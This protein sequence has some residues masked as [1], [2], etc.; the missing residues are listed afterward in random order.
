MATVKFSDE[1]PKPTSI[2]GTDRFLISDGV[3]GEAKA[4][5]FNQAK[6]Y[7]NITGIEMEPLV[8]GDSSATALVVANGPAGEQRTAEVSSG[9]WYDFGSGPV[10]ASADRRWKS[11]WNGTSWSLKDMGALP[12]Q[13]IDDLTPKGGFEGTSQELKDDI[14]E[15]KNNYFPVEDEYLHLFSDKNNAVYGFSNRNGEFDIKLTENAKNEIQ[16]VKSSNE[17]HVFSIEGEGREAALYISDTEM[18]LRGSQDNQSSP[19]IDPS[20]IYVSNISKIKSRLVLNSIAVG[21]A[22]AIGVDDAVKVALTDSGYTHPKMLYIPQGWNGYKYWLAITPTFGIIA[23]QVG[24]A[25]FEN[26]H[27]F[28]SNDAINWIEP[29]QN[30]IDVP[31]PFSFTNVVYPFNSDTHLLIGDDGWMYCYYRM[32]DM[33]REYVNNNPGE[34]GVYKIAMVCKKSRDGVNWSERIVVFG[35]DT[36]GVNAENLPKAQAYF[37]KGAKVQC[38]DMVKTSALLPIPPQKNQ[39]EMFIFRRSSFNPAE[40]NEPYT[41]DKIIDLENRPWGET[42]DPWHIDGE[43]VD[44]IYYLLIA[45]GLIDSPMASDLYLATSGDGWKFKV[46]PAPIYEGSTYRSSLTPFKI[47]EDGIDFLVMRADTSDG[48]QDLLKLEVKYKKG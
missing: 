41:I 13:P 44:G 35:D 46:H 23:E 10:Q 33:P 22:S 42:K 2:K 18:Y 45:V 4:P 12:M 20:K 6:E 19:N 16:N 28:A 9:K 5:D 7:L 30:P 11:Y 43:Y 29:T 39:T 17:G 26:P 47:H 31:A 40:N 14:D 48:H 27:V 15:V 25:Y 24:P 21:R 1:M 32:T 3:T 36:P 37:Y 8:G 34:A 38:Y